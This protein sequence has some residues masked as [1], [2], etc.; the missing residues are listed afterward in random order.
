MC[1]DNYQIE[2][3]LWRRGPERDT[4][5]SDPQST[6]SQRFLFNWRKNIENP[7]NSQS[8]VCLNLHFYLENDSAKIKKSKK[9]NST[10]T[11][12]I[13][14]FKTV[15]SVLTIW[16]RLMVT[17]IPT[18]TTDITWGGSTSGSSCLVPTW[19][20]GELL[21]W[22]VQSEQSICE[23]MQNSTVRLPRYFSN[24]FQRLFQV[25]SQYFLRMRAEGLGSEC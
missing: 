17:S 18:S 7:E 23:S 14:R 9:T 3:I 8:Y 24:C 20:P 1:S 2:S 16:T 4:E 12:Q 13:F 11:R 25:F 15:F 22:R 5:R 10:F 21:C 6:Q 19:C